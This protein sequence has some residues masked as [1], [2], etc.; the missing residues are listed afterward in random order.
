MRV[1]IW[2]LDG[3][4]INS[5][6][7][8]LK[9][10]DNNGD[11]DLIGYMRD[12]HQHKNVMADT[13]L[14][15]VEIMKDSIKR[16][17]KNYIVTARLCG[18]SDFYF[19]RKH[20][21]RGRGKNNVQLFHRGSIARYAEAD[22][23]K[24]IYSAKD[25]L[26]KNFY[27]RLIMARHPASTFT[28]YDDHQGVLDTAASLGMRAVDANVI[29]DILSVGVKLIGDSYLDDFDDDMADVDYLNEC[30]NMAYEESLY[31]V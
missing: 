3:T 21:L 23:V 31:A 25:A 18:N 28:V 20:G 7:R 6:H 30:L 11:L 1:N 27:L 29:N 10:I 24:E 19:L 13:V 15:L 22:I 17:E 12:A 8:T 4:V 16:G 2:D 9:H 5:A 26:Y 14:P